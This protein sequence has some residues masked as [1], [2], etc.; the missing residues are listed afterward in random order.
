MKDRGL[1]IDINP[2]TTCL[3]TGETNSVWYIFS[4][5][6]TGT[7][8][9]VLNVEYDYDFAL[10]EV[11]ENEN[12]C[13]NLLEQEPIRCNYSAEFGLTGLDYQDTFNGNLSYSANQSPWM[14]GLDVNAGQTFLLLINNWTGDDKGYNI[15]F[16]GTAIITDQIEPEMSMP[17]PPC[18]ST[19][20]IVLEINEPIDCS[21]I[22]QNSFIFNGA[23]NP[24]I[25]SIYGVNCGNISQQIII[26]YTFSDIPSG[27]YTLSIG[28]DIPLDIC[29]NALNGSFD[30]E[31]SDVP[32]LSALPG[33]LCI[34]SG[35]NTTITASI[36]GGIWN[37]GATTQSIT[38]APVQTTSYSYTFGLG[39]CVTTGNITIPVV[40]ELLASINPL[41]ITLCGTS[42]TPLTAIYPSGANITWSGP[43]ITPANEHNDV[44][45]VGPGEYTLFVELSGC[46]K[47]VTANVSL[48]PAEGTSSCLLLFVAPGATGD[49]LSSNSPTG[50]LTALSMASCNNTIIKMQVGS[51]QY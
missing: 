3:L 11:N 30:L 12:I 34:G 27:T 15:F 2:G 48:N 41:D 31:F 10:W 13:D 47:E 42:T 25:D 37:T 22:T 51:I 7:F 26:Q 18:T 14:Q 8:G 36:P 49:G 23:G 44:V 5:Q 50:L 16:T 46:T 39:N 21:T 40:S 33:Q 9:F 32:E 43:D 28:S 4:V 24:V 6:N 19:T 38:V 17:E 1:D 45:E 29:G 20:N 35:D